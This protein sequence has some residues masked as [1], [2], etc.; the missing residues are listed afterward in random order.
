MLPLSAKIAELRSSVVRPSLP[1][2]LTPREV[3]VLVL[4]AQGK[5]NKEI[6]AELFIAERTASN[7][8]SNIL[9]RIKCGNRTEAAA[10]AHRHGLVKP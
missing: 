2:G 8:V 6:A 7:H 10:F 9:A 5:T 1:G 3:D 4:L